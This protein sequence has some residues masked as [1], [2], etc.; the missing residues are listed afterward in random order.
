M[1]D[2]NVHGP[3]EPLDP[4]LEPE[5]PELE[6]LDDPELWPHDPPGWQVTPNDVQ[7]WQRAPPA[8]H[9]VSATPATHVA[10]ESQQPLQA[11][12]AH[13]IALSTSIPEPPP[14]AI[15]LLPAV[16]PVPSPAPDPAVP[17][18]PRPPLLEES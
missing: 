12:G 5:P 18:L 9:K 10:V 1:H 4:P 13:A 11:P 14:L 2:W 7:S 3:L 8:P 15:P 17:L 6:P 16:L